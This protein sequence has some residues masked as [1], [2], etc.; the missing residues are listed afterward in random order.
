MVF[1]S[2]IVGFLM[3]VDEQL[4]LISGIFQSEGRRAKESGA[5]YNKP[6]RRSCRFPVPQG[7]IIDDT[8][9][10]IAKRVLLV[11]ARRGKQKKN[12]SSAAIRGFFFCTG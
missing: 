11:K 1:L 5:A 7:Y 12:P 2:I 6:Y 4:L 3:N 10:I 9:P 8:V